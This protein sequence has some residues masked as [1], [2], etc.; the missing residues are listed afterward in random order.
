M[1]GLCSHFLPLGCSL[2]PEAGPAQMETERLSPSLSPLLPT[3]RWLGSEGGMAVGAAPAL[4]SQ[5]ADSNLVCLGRSP[6]PSPHA[7]PHFCLPRDL[8][9]PLLPN[10][11]M[12]ER[13]GE[14]STS[15]VSSVPVPSLWGRWLPFCGW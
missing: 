11:P 2:S 14:L 6:E 4:L 7:A 13:R 10:P 1:Q 15:W 12:M 5:L 9:P 8:S 3:R